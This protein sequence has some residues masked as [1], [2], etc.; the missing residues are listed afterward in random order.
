MKPIKRFMKYLGR[1]LPEGYYA[2]CRPDGKE[3]TILNDGGYVY[4]FYKQE[5]EEDFELC[6]SLVQDIIRLTQK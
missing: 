6:C 3:V 1:E 5:I 2:K 4:L